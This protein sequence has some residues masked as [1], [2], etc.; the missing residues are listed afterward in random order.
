MKKLMIVCV[1][2]CLAVAAYA[3]NM[4]NEI[5]SVYQ[6]QH[7]KSEMNLRHETE[8]VQLLDYADLMP[9]FFGGDYALRSFMQS[10]NRYPAEALRADVQGTVYVS[11][12]INEN[13]RITNPIIVKGIGFGLDEEAVRLVKMMPEWSPAE[14]GGKPIKMVVTLPIRFRLAG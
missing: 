9:V 10:N 5:A 14:L 13:G 2:V 8:P 1:M 7:L 11:F 12:V 6:P 3:Q 4:A